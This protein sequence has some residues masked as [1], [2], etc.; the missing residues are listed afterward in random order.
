[1]RKNANPDELKCQINFR[2]NRR[3][4]KIINLVYEAICGIL[5][6]LSSE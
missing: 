1:V 4:R 5:D 2:L 6:W 3:L